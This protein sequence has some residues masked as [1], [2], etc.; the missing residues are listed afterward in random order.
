MSNRTMYIIAFSVYMVFVVALVALYYFYQN[1]SDAMLMGMYM[2]SSG[3][4][5]AT[6]ILGVIFLREKD[7]QAV[8]ERF[9]MR[10]AE[11]S[12]WDKKD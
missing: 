11:D 7:R 8:I 3:L 4:M 6:V 10:A 12:D 2:L 9:E 5:G 1:N